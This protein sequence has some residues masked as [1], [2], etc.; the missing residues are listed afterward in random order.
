MEGDVHLSRK[1]EAFT[2]HNNSLLNWKTIGNPHSISLMMMWYYK[3]FAISNEFLIA[4]SA[5]VRPSESWPW[6]FWSRRKFHS[7]AILIFHVFQILASTLLRIL[8]KIWCYPWMRN[9]Y[10]YELK[11]T[12]L[13]IVKVCSVSKKFYKIHPRWALS[14][15]SCISCTLQDPSPNWFYHGRRKRNNMCGWLY[16]RLFR[17][18]VKRQKEK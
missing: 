17:H 6:P 15:S 7:T 10:L 18:E 9:R 8:D 2:D 5:Y 12:S 1:I 13:F 16:K 11:K 4:A 3:S 14:T